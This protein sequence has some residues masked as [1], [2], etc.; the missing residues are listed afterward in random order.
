M[1]VTQKIQKKS[2]H[3]LLEIMEEFSEVVRFKINKQNQLSKIRDLTNMA[4]L[5]PIFESVI[6]RMNSHTLVKDTPQ[7]PLTFFSL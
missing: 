1:S 3:R 2:T 7:L 4:D 6:S 5:L